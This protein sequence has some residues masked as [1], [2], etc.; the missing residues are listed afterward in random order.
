MVPTRLQC[1]DEPRR[2]L[3]QQF[4]RRSRLAAAFGADHTS[5]LRRQRSVRVDPGL[6]R[7]MRE[8]RLDP[9]TNRRNLG[10]T[11]PRGELTPQFQDSVSFL[12]A[13]ADFW[14]IFKEKG[15]K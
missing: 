11:L 5:S 1:A 3:E 8:R 9:H 12:P 10:H 15:L 2:E 13:G 4:G 14:P 6:R 7:D